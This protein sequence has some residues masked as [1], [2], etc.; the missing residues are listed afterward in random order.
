MIKKSPVIR[1]EVFL[2]K[3]K[4]ESTPNLEELLPSLR[5]M[6]DKTGILLSFGCIMFAMLFCYLLQK[7]RARHNNNNNTNNN[8]NDGGGEGN[9]DAEQFDPEEEDEEEDDELQPP[10]LEQQPPP[11][12]FRPSQNLPRNDSQVSSVPSSWLCASTK[13][14]IYQWAEYNCALYRFMLPFMPWKAYF[15]AIWWTVLYGGIKLL[16]GLAL[17]LATL[18]F[19]STHIGSLASEAECGQG[20]QCTICFSNFRAPIK[21]KCSNIFC[22]ES[23]RTWLDREVT[24]PICRAVVTREDNHFSNGDSMLPCVF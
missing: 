19:R 9:A 14:R 6:E 24:C 12:T 11:P 15:G 10:P 21:L 13:R 17:V 16:F 4:I 7:Y 1:V 23:I 22:A 2:P 18:R 3:F 20:E 8:N 5:V